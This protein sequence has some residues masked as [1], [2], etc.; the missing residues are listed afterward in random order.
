MSDLVMSIKQRLR[1]L[2]PDSVMA[3]YRVRQHSQA[4]RRNVDVFPPNSRDARK[5]LYLTPDTYRV[6]TGSPHN[7]PTDELVSVGVRDE[8]LES[9]IGVEGIEVV[10]A[11]ATLRP[12][13]RGLR[14]VEPAV[15]PYSIVAAAEAFEDIGGV[16][17]NSADLIRTYQRLADTGRRIGLVPV[18]A[19]ELPDPR[20]TPVTVPAVI[21]FA[22]V[23]LHDIGGGS[24]AAQIAF[25][26]L[27][28]GFHVTYVAM[29]PSGEGVDLGLRYMHPMLEQFSIEAFDLDD[30]DGR[31]DAGIVILEAPAQPFL[32]PTRM[33][34]Q[35][36]WRIV[37]DIIDD[38]TDFALGGYWYF[39]DVEAEIVFLADTVVASAPDLVRHGV[40]LGAETSLIPNA[41]NSPLF[42]PVAGEAPSDLPSGHIIG[43]MGS[44]YG[45][46]FDWDALRGVAD[47]FP[48]SHIVVI[49]DDHYKRP[50][51]S[52]VIYL[53]LKPQSDLPAYVQRFDVGI[54][55]FEVSEATH[56]VSPL[57]VYEYLASGAPVAAPPL[58]ALEGLD[59]V[60]V[61]VD[62][63]A[64]VT[65]AMDAPKPDRELALEQHSWHERVVQLMQSVGIDLPQ[66][67][68][69][70]V[71]VASRVPAHYAREDRWIRAE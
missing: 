15:V 37:Y 27:R 33:L 54:V 9:L 13:M 36:G 68:G 49:G 2:I 12:S 56:A 23:P 42:G 62:L 70:E 64:A 5:W 4:M 63:V 48:D 31:A 50:M 6:I 17:D 20:R 14:V 57:K 44:L 38:W 3:R 19:D 8:A 55:P 32:V 16:K 30:I 46:W 47:A 11:G 18:V 26:L 61:D 52:N 51:P 35:R 69:V 65:R 43:Y 25:E 22:A 1:P 29:Y 53:G 59:G 67:P 40:K 71:K 10:V 7:E 66:V 41:V 58:R 39:P 60:Y 34:K 21:V 24:R 45:D 28:T